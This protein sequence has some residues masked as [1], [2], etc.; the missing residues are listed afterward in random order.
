MCE[1]LLSINPEHVKNIF[2][3]VKKYEYRKVAC[4]RTI[5]K[6]LI[7]ATTPIKKVVGEAQVLGVLEMDK[8][9]LWRETQSESGISSHFYFEYYSN[10]TKAV[11]YHLGEIIKYNEP[12][13]LKEYGLGAAPQSFV[14]IENNDAVS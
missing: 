12:K 7:Y 2:D 8:E 11:A 13:D 6:I 9:D 10:K 3:G 1:M 14:Y 5:D 4:K